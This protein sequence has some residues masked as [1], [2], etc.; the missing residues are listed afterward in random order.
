MNLQILEEASEELAET[1]TWYEAERP[2]LGAEYL[3]AMSALVQSALDAP[4]QFPVHTG[5]T[6]RVPA[7][8]KDRASRVCVTPTRW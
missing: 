5:T 8:G 1:A 7:L 6:R 2:G 3:D 4:M